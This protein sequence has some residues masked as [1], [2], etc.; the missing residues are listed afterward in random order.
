[1]L[2]KAKWKKASSKYTSR[3]LKKT[4]GKSKFLDAGQIYNLYNTLE[5]EKKKQSK[6]ALNIN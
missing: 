6:N 4:K 3:L 1:M 5:E 2:M